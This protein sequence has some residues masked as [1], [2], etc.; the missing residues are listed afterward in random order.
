MIEELFVIKDG[1]RLKVDLNTPSGITLNFKSN[2][3]GDLSK[4]TCSYTY[5]F[6]LPLT[7]NNRI[8]F[9][10]A[11]DVRT[12][13]SMVRRRLKAEYNQNGIPL[14]S[15]ANLY[16]ESTESAFNA[17]MTWGVIDGLQ[18]LKDNDISIRELGLVAK[19]VF[20][21]C[22]AKIDEWKNTLD[23]AK[24]LYNAGLPYISSTGWKD[25]YDTYSVFPLPVIPV[26]RLI[27]LINSKYSTKFNLGEAFSY[28]GSTSNK[29][30]ISYGV[31]PC[32]N[33]EAPADAMNE[34]V[35]ASY[36]GSYMYDSNYAGVSH[37][38]L[39]G[40][41]D[42]APT[43]D[44]YSLVKIS[45]GRTV[46]VKMNS[47]IGCEIQLDGF[48]K[49][50]FTHEPNQY[51]GQGTVEMGAPDTSGITPKLV[52]YYTTDGTTATQCGSVEGK[53]SY[54][55]DWCWHFNFSKDEGK[56][57]LTFEAPAGSI[58]FL[59]IEADANNLKL[60]AATIQKLIRFYS[61]EDAS[62]IKWS[63][64]EAEAG[65]YAMDLMSNLPDISC[66][67]FIKALFF[68]LGAFPSLN[69]S[70]EIVPVYYIDIK[71][72]LNN[73]KI[74][75]WSKRITTDVNVLP[76][77]IT[78]E[79]SGFGQNNYYLMKNDNI[80]GDG[81]EDE[82]DVYGSGI[83]C[84]KVPNE[85]LDR[86]KTIIQL[87]FYGPYIKNKKEPHLATGNTLKFWYYDNE[88]KTKEAKPCFGMIIPFQQM[89]YGSPTGVVW[90]SMKIW[91][92]FP[93]INS[94]SSYS[95]LSEILAD[96]I[97][98]TENFNL[99]EIDLRDID[100]ST[101]IYLNKYNSYFAIVFITRDSKGV[102]K[103]E[104]IKLP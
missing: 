63:Y 26:Y 78:Y 32:V 36:I 49:M 16:I 41:N 69:T 53:F 24:P 67:T 25:Q 30:L 13:S 31:I 17:V 38:L 75:D 43:I 35:F 9:E 55:N 46:G 7:I 59:A 93:Q 52:A 62:L 88:V 66:M 47:N 6:K 18:V 5:T 1:N 91:N 72:N 99:N 14:F 96:P 29:D 4:I 42:P 98:I 57:R 56:D 68:M 2:I 83:G 100:Y 37:V 64:P 10:S 8:I 58:I 81:V 34:S 92:E 86:N 97:V 3:F 82:S 79:V 54:S 28:G 60:K 39:G 94:E 71:N 90:M 101:P 15:N 61:V 27:Q 84:I 11:E 89:E 74:L 33:A 44:L 104:L 20:G 85:L 48:L 76:S 22:N 45:D 95:Y 50:K 77:K 65:S 87:P 80:E 12:S 51:N 40:K 21:P 103:C 102:C 19:P 70:N 23:F 73:G